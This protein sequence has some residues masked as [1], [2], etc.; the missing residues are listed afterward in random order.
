MK[1]DIRIVYNR[2]LGGWFVVRGQ[3]QTPLSGRFETKADALASLARG[4][5]TRDR[6]LGSAAETCVDCSHP[7][8]KHYGSLGDCVARIKHNKVCL[9]RGYRPRVDR[10]LGSA[11]RKPNICVDC[12]AEVDDCDSCYEIDCDCNL[13]GHKLAR[14]RSYC[15]ACSRKFSAEEAREYGFGEGDQP[16]TCPSC[17]GRIEPNN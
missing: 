8:A 9:C 2:L 7:A 3:H 13:S 17:G 11:A 16:D 10:A 4:R 14:G 1:T 15:L 6:A 5:A 12:S